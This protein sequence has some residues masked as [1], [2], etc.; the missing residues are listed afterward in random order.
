MKKI[1]VEIVKFDDGTVNTAATKAA[2]EATL[3]SLVKTSEQ[4]QNEIM[5]YIDE[6][7]AAHPGKR[8]PIM[9]LATQV[10]TA[11]GTTTE[12]WSSRGKLVAEALKN[13]RYSAKRGPSG[14]ICFT[15]DLV[16]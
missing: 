9:Q 1:S 8:V 13:N 15:A 3:A 7:L 14:G 12:Q 6:V 2:F 5:P 10:L 4:G 11:M 16:K